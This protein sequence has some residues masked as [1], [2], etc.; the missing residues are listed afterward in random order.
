MD[1]DILTEEELFE[2]YGKIDVEEMMKSDVIS[3]EVAGELYGVDMESGKH[4]HLIIDK[5]ESTSWENPF[6]FAHEIVN[7]NDIM[8]DNL[9]ASELEAS[10]EENGKKKED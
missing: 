1:K 10:I 9:T 2:L 5:V 4:E 6:R 7:E 3:S 8:S